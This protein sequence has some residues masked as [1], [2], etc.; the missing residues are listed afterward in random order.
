MGYIRGHMLYKNVASRL[1]IDFVTPISK[2][3]TKC[4]RTR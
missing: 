4:L 3:H 2:P 1:R